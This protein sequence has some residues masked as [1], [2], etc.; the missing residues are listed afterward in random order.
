MG[1]VADISFNDYSAK[2]LDEMEDGVL[3]ALERCGMQAEGY[4][5]DLCP[6]DT[7]RLR[8]SITYQVD[9]KERAV[10]T[11]SNVEYAA[12]VELGGARQRAQPYL[13]PAITDHKQT[14]R[15]IINDELGG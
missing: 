4:A 8:N 14:Y 3:R 11:G 2:I 12:P 10:Y 6:V 1:K 7:G 13:K 5:K 15:N 9:K